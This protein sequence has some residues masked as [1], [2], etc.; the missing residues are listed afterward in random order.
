MFHATPATYTYGNRPLLFSH[1]ERSR[2]LSEVLYVVEFKLRLALKATRCQVTLQPPKLFRSFVFDELN[3]FLSLNFCIAPIIN[4]LVKS[5][6]F[7]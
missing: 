2:G 6:P 3:K 1:D 7:N 5:H 4:S